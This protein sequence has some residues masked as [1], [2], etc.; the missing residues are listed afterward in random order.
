MTYVYQQVCV[1]LDHKLNTEIYL[2]YGEK[3]LKKIRPMNFP[4]AWERI[5]SVSM[6]LY[7][8]LGLILH[9]KTKP[10]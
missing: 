3:Y 2:F 10:L 7:N 5:D 8:Q 1:D 9:N 4:A 6:I